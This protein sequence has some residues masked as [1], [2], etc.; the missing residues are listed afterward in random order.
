MF[1][2]DR[3]DPT[4][5]KNLAGTSSSQDRE[6]EGQR[7]YAFA[8]SQMANEFGYVLI[9]H[10]SVMAARQLAALW[11]KVDKV[12]SPNGGIFA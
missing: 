9:G 5:A 2:S 4:R 3:I 7:R 8:L 10:C 11:Q 1:P 12:T 6:F